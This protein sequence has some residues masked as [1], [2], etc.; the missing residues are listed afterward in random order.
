M[1][2]TIERVVDAGDRLGESPVWDDRD[3][4]LWWVD[5]LGHRLHRFD[6]SS[7]AHVVWPLPAQV[8]SIGLREAGG[9]VVAT[10]EGFGRHMP[11]DA[12][13]AMLSS[14]LAGMFDTRFNDGRC[15]RRGRFWS[16][17]VQEKRV[18]GGAA[19][20]RLDRAGRCER[21][22]DGL[23][24]TNAIAWSP[25]GRTMY[26]ADSHPREI[27]ACEFDQDAGAVG[28]RRLF[29]RWPENWGQPDGATI[30]VDGCLW[31]AAIHGAAVLRYAPDG[32]LDRRVPMPVTQPTSCTFGGASMA[33]LF[34]T[35]ARRGHDAAMLA[36]TPLAGDVFALD[37]GVAGIPEPRCAA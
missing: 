17:T 31:I 18:V 19:L 15:D 10:R 22:V 2:S 26:F 11:G 29:A 23:T 13:I 6:P 34:V 21:M 24:V 1:A 16:G 35:S 25:D 8:G 3:G 30:D 32:R 20:Y 37:A 33:T 9:L 5:I 14:P 28:R 36:R 12:T 4:S 7:G 27:Y